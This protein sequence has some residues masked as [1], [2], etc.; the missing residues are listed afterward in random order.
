VRGNIT[1]MAQKD[2]RNVNIITNVHHLA[3]VGNLCEDRGNTL[4]MD[5]IQDYERNMGYVK[6]SH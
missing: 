5:R 3:V 2:E 4:K 1:A 6:K